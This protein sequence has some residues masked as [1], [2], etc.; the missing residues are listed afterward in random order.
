MPLELMAADLTRRIEA[1]DIFD[2]TDSVKDQL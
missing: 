1:G 2:V